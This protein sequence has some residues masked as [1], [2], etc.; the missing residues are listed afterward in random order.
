[1]NPSRIIEAM[2]RQRRQPLESAQEPRIGNPVVTI[3]PPPIHEPPVEWPDGVTNR[4]QPGRWPAPQQ[5]V[6]PVPPLLPP[7]LPEPVYPTPP[8]KDLSQRP[9][10]PVGA[11]LTGQRMPADTPPPTSSPNFEGWYNQLPPDQKLKYRPLYLQWL[12]SQNP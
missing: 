4:Q 7:N 11:A 6:E 1:M 3:E 8:R 5:P 10:P 9:I 12:Q 2:L